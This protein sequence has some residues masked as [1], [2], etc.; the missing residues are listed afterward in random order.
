MTMTYV[1]GILSI[2]CLAQAALLFKV[3]RV[4]GAVDRAE[5]RLAH[6]SGALALLTETTE[7]GF[8]AT[9]LEIA[10]R[11]PASSIRADDRV[12][13]EPDPL[14]APRVSTS[15]VVRAV[16]SG[17][18]VPEIAAEEQ[19]SEGEVRLR[20]ALAADRAP[21]SKPRARQN[22]EDGYGALHA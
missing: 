13:S 15:R 6:F 12:G 2:L 19:V 8:R 20:L 21:R 22:M 11:H 3:L 5:D 9:A 4:L 16:R 18:A 17:W 1:V 10:R 7:D 14:S